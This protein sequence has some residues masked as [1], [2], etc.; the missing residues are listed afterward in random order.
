MPDTWFVSFAI[1]THLTAEQ[2]REAVIRAL[3]NE[4]GLQLS[5]YERRTVC[6]EPYDGIPLDEVE[7]DQNLTGE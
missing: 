3:K 5:E 6:V 7:P 1:Q 2:T 4:I